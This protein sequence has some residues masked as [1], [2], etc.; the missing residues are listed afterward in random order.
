MDGFGLR[1]PTSLGR[2]RQN[3]RD[4]HRGNLIPSHL[5]PFCSRTAEKPPEKLRTGTCFFLAPIHLAT[6]EQAS[7]MADKFYPPLIRFQWQKAIYYQAP[8]L[9]NAT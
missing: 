4:Y 3:H 1:N 2:N 9:F 5:L 6:G 8:K 7:S